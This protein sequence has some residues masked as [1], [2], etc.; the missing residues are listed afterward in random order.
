M[1]I[2][3]CKK[4][5]KNKNPKCDD[6]LNCEW[7]PKNGDILGH[8]TQIKNKKDILKTKNNKQDVQKTKNNK[9]DIPKTKKIYK[10]KK[11]NIKCDS[12]KKN[13]EPKC[14]DQSH[15]EWIPKNGDILGHCIEK[16]NNDILLSI[17]KKLIILKDEKDILNKITDFF[18]ENKQ[19]LIDY[20][21]LGNDFI[22]DA[23]FNYI[24]LVVSNFYNK[25]N[26]FSFMLDSAKVINNDKDII[27]E[28]LIKLCKKELNMKNNKQN[29]YKTKKKTCKT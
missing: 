24:D 29:I 22:E 1:N 28:Y 3:N 11:N 14:S 15:C 13:K 16:N 9:Q 10:L 21:E 25:N 26:R 4:F 8:C 6:Q 5:K 19:E 7:I 12:L 17:I 20:T 27:V 23:L 2:N 18:I